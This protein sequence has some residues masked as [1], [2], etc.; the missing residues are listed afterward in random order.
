MTHWIENVAIELAKR[1]TEEHVIASG[2]SIERRLKQY[3]LQTT[4]THSEKFHI[5]YLN[6]TTNT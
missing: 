5:L 3:G 2:T 1:D 6:L 4:T